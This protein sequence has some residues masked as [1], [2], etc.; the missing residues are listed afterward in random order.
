MGLVPFACL[1]VGIS[2]THAV[3]ACL[4]FHLLQAGE[5][6]MILQARDNSC[7]TDGRLQAARQQMQPDADRLYGEG[8]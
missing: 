3:L 2:C 4:H 1:L 7:A 5:L 8:A 6:S